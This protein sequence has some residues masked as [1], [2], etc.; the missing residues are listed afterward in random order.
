M[1]PYA[2]MDAV[3]T[4]LVFAKLYPAVKRNAK[5]SDVYEKI[6]IPACRFLT[7]VQDV[8]VPFD[9]ERLSKNS[10]KISKSL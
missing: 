5:L 8:G 3:V 10:Y 1:T 4:L 9:K 7:D 2:A 6:L